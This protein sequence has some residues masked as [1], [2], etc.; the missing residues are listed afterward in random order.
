MG[1]DDVTG[2]CYVG[3]AVLSVPP[4]KTNVNSD[5]RDAEEKTPLAAL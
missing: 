1:F 5:S 3:D 4:I 2:I